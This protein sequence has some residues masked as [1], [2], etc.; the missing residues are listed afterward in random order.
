MKITNLSIDRFGPRCN[1]QLDQLSPELNLVYGPN[2]TGKT[3]IL[4]V[5]TVLC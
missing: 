3:S 5:L 4:E 1:L 2:D